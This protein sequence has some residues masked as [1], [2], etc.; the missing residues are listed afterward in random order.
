MKREKLLKVLHSPRLTEKATSQ[1][2]QYVFE[3]D[4]AANKLDI[5]A[6]VEQLFQ[7]KVKAVNIVRVKGAVASKM[8]RV[9][10][11][12]SSWKKAYVALQPGQLINLE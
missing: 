11:K 9:V 1:T 10:G 4:K 2:G 6:A 7:V 3:V 8:G 5:K 12:Q